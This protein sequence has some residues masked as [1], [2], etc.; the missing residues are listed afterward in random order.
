[1]T[2]NASKRLRWAVE[3]LRVAP[4]DRLLEVG[5]GHGVAVS[6]V[7]ERLD[8]GRIT[9]IDRSPKMIEAAK[10]RNRA[11]ARKV[12]FVTASLADADLADEIYDKVFA[13]HVAALHRAG[14]ELDVVRRR[15]A[16]GGRLYLFSQAPGWDAPEHAER[17]AAELAAVLEEAGFGLEGTPVKDLGTGFAAA[18][19][20]QVSGR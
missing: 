13:V 18:V 19:V 15:L 17:F 4:A 12:R 8:G 11:H 16:P 10:K 20:A 14:D 9:A 5:C 1:M 3:L 6:L 2:R 7:C